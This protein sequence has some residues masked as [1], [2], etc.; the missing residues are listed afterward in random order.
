MTFNLSGTLNAFRLLYN[1]YLLKPQMVIANFN[2]LPIP[3]RSDQIKAVVVDKDNCISYPNESSIWPSYVDKWEAL[4]KQYPGKAVLIVSNTAGSNDDPNYEEAKLIEKRT[5]VE[6]LRHSTK[7]PGCK[8]DILKY[9]ISNKIVKSPSEIAV[10]GDRLL[11]DISMAN[12]LGGYGIW[13]KDGVRASSSSISKFEK[14]LYN[15]LGF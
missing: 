5:G 10:I 13:I 7:K 8:D 6:V 14:S 2:Q 9:F 11:T 4:K 1:P 3:I 12:M 15:F